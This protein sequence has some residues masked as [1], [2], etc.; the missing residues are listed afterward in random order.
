MRLRRR[1]CSYI[2]PSTSH[3]VIFSAALIAVIQTSRLLL[4]ESSALLVK[5]NNTHGRA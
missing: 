1:Q 3:S 2:R 4:V 5:F